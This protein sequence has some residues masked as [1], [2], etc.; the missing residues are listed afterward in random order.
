[1]NLQLEKQEKQLF[2][3]IPLRKSLIPKYMLMD[4]KTLI[5]MLV[6]TKE[7]GIS[8]TKLVQKIKEYKITIL[9]LIIINLTQTII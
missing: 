6:N 4:T 8:Q 3:V 5:Q 2:Q 1:M 9:N 7:L